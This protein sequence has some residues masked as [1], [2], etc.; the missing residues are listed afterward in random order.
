M[1]LKKIFLFA[2]FF[3]AQSLLKQ[4]NFQKIKRNCFKKENL[5][6]LITGIGKKQVEETLKKHQPTCDIAINIGLCGGI[7][8]LKIGDVLTPTSVFTEE[9]LQKNNISNSFSSDLLITLLNPLYNPQ[10]FLNQWNL[11]NYSSCLGADLEA[12]FLKDYFKKHNISFTSIKIVSDLGEEDF[13][14]HFLQRKPL[15]E[16]KLEEV[17]KKQL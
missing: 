8:N 14:T 10:N 9:E 1:N 3:E 11:N 13:K 16:K 5:E 7:K 17:A 12:G 6:V 4:G 2:T 15:L